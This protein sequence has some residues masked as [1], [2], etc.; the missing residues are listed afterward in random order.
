MIYISSG[1][2]KSH[3]ILACIATDKQNQSLA[4]IS[5]TSLNWNIPSHLILQSLQF[6]IGIML[7]NFLDHK[8]HE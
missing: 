6:V 7:R 8:Y 4:N 2:N 1:F 5:I 3:L